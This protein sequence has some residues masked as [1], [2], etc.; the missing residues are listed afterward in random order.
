MKLNTNQIGLAHFVAS[1]LLSTIVA[2]GTFGLR[3][4]LNDL[5]EQ[6]EIQARGGL[7]AA[8]GRLWTDRDTGIVDEIE[9]TAREL[10][11]VENE[12]R[13]DRFAATIR[14]AR[15]TLDFM[16][17]GSVRQ[18][19]DDDVRFSVCRPEI[20]SPRTAAKS[21]RTS[22][23]YFKHKSGCCQPCSTRWGMESSSLT[24]RAG[25]LPSIRPR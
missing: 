3:R 14:G 2:F 1:T 21:W 15:L 17:A 12:T 23:T 16:A 18:P 9:P 20:G 11:T 25:L 6:N 8:L 19:G 4:V 10:S 7:K 5:G 22:T 13:A 24:R